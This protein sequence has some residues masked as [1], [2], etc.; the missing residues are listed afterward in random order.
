MILIK[1]A[2]DSQ[3]SAFFYY[4]IIR[5]IFTEHLFVFFIFCHNI[6]FPETKQNS[7][8]TPINIPI[9]VVNFTSSG[10]T[11]LTKQGQK[12]H[13]QVYGYTTESGSM[14]TYSI[15]GN[16]PTNYLPSKEVADSVSLLD[17]KSLPL[18][19]DTLGNV[20]LNLNALNGNISSNTWM[21]GQI[22]WYIGM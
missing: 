5:S 18:I 12:M 17:G 22:E 16:I 9:N 4:T 2:G 11:R 10:D 6:F 14:E 13:L 15:I 20:Y 19:V 21:F 3:S 1:K 7:D 8:I